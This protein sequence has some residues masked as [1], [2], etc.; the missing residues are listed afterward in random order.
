MEGSGRGSVACVAWD[1]RACYE[2]LLEGI[3]GVGGNVENEVAKL[4]SELRRE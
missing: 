4:G 1:G 3:V 2:L